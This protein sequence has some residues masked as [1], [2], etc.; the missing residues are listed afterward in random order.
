MTLGTGGYT[1][2]FLVVSFKGFSLQ[3]FQGA[4]DIKLDGQQK[5]L[6]AR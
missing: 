4:E 2:Q 1:C 6:P 5:Q 3:G